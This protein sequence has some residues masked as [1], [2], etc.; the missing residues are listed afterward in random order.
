LATDSNSW[1]AD[2]SLA[3]G[4]TDLLFGRLSGQHQAAIRVATHEL[5]RVHRPPQ[6]VPLDLSAPKA[7]QAGKQGG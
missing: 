1:L 7:A 4:N 2:V 6:Q 5:V 3:N